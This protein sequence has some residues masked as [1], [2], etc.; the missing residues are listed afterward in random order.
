MIDADQAVTEKPL[1]LDS[2]DPDVIKVMVSP[3][4]KTPMKVSILSLD[5]GARAPA[6]WNYQNI[7]VFGD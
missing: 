2:P 1:C 7:D 6:Q 4:R 5:K 3:A